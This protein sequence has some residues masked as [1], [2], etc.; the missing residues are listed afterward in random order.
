MD[1]QCYVS[2]SMLPLHFHCN[3]HTPMQRFI[4]FSNYAYFVT[5][6]S[7]SH[8]MCHTFPLSLSQCTSHSSSSSNF[9]LPI[10]SSCSS[11]ATLIIYSN[12][13]YASEPESVSAF[14]LQTQ[15][16][17]HF[18]P[19]LQPFLKTSPS[20]PLLNPHLLHLSPPSTEASPPLHKSH[21]L[22]RL[23]FLIQPHPPLPHP[24]MASATSSV[25]TL[26]PSDHPC[27]T[28]HSSPFQ[29]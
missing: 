7:L 22:T 17:C 29:A 20:H 6:L 21:A 28:Y 9:S 2:G 14:E 23:L 26:T 18:S 19:Q 25:T 15:K 11:S 16:H 1:N 12:L 4:W 3:K 24:S 8:T 5:I 27:Q 10:L 13:V